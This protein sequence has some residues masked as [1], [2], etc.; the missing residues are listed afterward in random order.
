VGSVTL[1]AS[2]PSN[3]DPWFPLKQLWE[4]LKLHFPSKQKE[5]KEIVSLKLSSFE[6]FKYVYICGALMFSCVRTINFQFN[7]FNRSEISGQTCS[8]TYEGTAAP[9]VCNPSSKILMLFKCGLD[10]PYCMQVAVGQYE[11]SEVLYSCTVAISSHSAI[12]V[13]PTAIAR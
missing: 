12:S 3:K 7:K 10:K 8:S 5:L 4:T 1:H 9:E 2:T 13:P 11:C 6:E